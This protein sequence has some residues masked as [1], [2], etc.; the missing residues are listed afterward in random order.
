MKLL[1]NTPDYHNPSSGGVA[2]YYYGML[3]Y[4][5]ENVKYNIIGRRRGLSGAAWLLWDVIKFIH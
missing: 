3:G 2:S 5:N 1:I 4:W